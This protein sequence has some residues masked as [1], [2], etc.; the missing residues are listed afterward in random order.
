MSNANTVKLEV[1]SSPELARLVRMTAA[2]VAALSGMS[3][4][5]IEDMRM[6]AEEAFIFAS[7]IDPDGVLSIAFDVDSDGVSMVF[8]TGVDS[9]PT[10]EE[11]DP[12]A[13]ADLILGAVCDSYEKLAS[14]V[15]LSLEVRTDA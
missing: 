2:N 12:A 6:V 1:A 7:S 11:G 15:R 9:I 14:P 5:R 3:V 13:Y 10:L 4:D 8:T